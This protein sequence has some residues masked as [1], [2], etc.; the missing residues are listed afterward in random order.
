MLDYP[1]VA[2]DFM[3]RDHAEFVH[4]V[5]ELIALL[6]QPDQPDAVD[7]RLDRLLEHTRAHFAAEEEAMRAAAFPPY[8][9]HKGE[10]DRV[11]ADMQAHLA[12][13][14]QSRDADALRDW[15]QGAVSDW[16]VTHVGMMDFVTARFIS[17]TARGR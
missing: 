10:H 2:L 9:V 4:S 5:N 7:D 3:N 1:Q 16:F 8:P 14:R 11:L 15:L 13:W 6:A 17:Q 12:A